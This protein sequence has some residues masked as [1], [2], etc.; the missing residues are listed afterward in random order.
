MTTQDDFRRNALRCFMRF[1]DRAERID[2]R[3]LVETFVSVGPLA[4]VLESTNHQI[5]FG[6]RGTGKTHALKY[7]LHKKIDED[8]IPIYIDCQNIGSNQ[9]IYDDKD[10]SIEERGTRL[11]IDVVSSLHF[12]LLNFFSDPQQDWDLSIIAPRLD[13]LVDSI[14]EIRVHG[15]VEREKRETSQHSLSD[16]TSLAVT[17]ATQSSLQAT[18]GASTA[19]SRGDERRR[20]EQ[21]VEHSWI[22]FGFIGQKL[23]QVAECA[24]DCRIWILIDEW[25]TVSV[26][27]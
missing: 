22:D 16:N 19:A 17:I 14:S 1:R 7:F 23:L 20:L 27:I 18:Y 4:D 2:P 5:I 11:L 25:S 15:S 8:D 12:Q 3:Q 21:G 10:L 13:A 24:T 9:S 6:R 26:D